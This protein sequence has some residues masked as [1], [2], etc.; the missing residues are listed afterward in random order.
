MA[1]NLLVE[2]HGPVRVVTLNKPARRNAVDLVLRESLASAINSAMADQV[3]RVLV[4]TGTGEIFSA[5]GDIAVT[6]GPAATQARSTVTA[7]Q[8]VVLA[9]CDGPKPVVAAVEGGAY[10][11]GLGV[12]AA[13][14]RVV[15]SSSARFGATFA[16]IGLAGDAGVFWSLPRRVG[17]AR[18]KQL[19]M[20]A[21]EVSAPEAA[22]IGLVDALAEPGQ[23]LWA[24]L[25]DAARLAAGPPLALAA[26]KYMANHGPADLRAVLDA[27]TERQAAL[28]DTEDFEEGLAAL[29]DRRPPTF[30]GR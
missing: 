26:I 17:P 13:C 20:M 11:A 15:A 28:C 5:G 3:I 4:L 6:P 9:I 16:R 19:L 27:E 8:Q 1:E 14:D 25:T 23:V 24:A 21:A 22:T 12:M 10:G 7:L 29:R 30:R 18:A 2:N